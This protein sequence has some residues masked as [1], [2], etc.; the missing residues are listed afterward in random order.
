VKI[1]PASLGTYGLPTARAHLRYIQ[2]DGVTREG[3]PGELY[4]RD[5][6]HADGRD[7]LERCGNDDRQFRVI[8]SAEDGAEYSDLKPYIRR[9]MA[10]VE[11]DLGTRL[12][13]VAVDHFNT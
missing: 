5:T 7:F 6:D 10:Q 4:G 9:L 13:W 2:R 3:A 12:D 1:R 11:E 8:V